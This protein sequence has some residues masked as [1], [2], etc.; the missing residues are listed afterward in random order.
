MF[1]FLLPIFFAGTPAFMEYDSMSFVTTEFAPI[2][3]P[4][5]I[6][7]LDV[8]VTFAPN[9]TSLPILN[10]LV[11]SAFCYMIRLFFLKL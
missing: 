7:T 11:F 5:S 4:V 9:Q 6:V 2:T 10:F 8:T 3:A 1:H